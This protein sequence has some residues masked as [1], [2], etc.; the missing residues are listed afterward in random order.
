MSGRV[1]GSRENGIAGK[2]PSEPMPFIPDP[3][4]T[5]RDMRA[6]KVPCPY[7]KAKI[8]VS[9]WTLKNHHGP[10]EVSRYPHKSRIKAAWKKGF[11]GRG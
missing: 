10:T 3:N 6:L 1:M 7:C 9:C 11:G 2:E 4:I 5:D 8:G